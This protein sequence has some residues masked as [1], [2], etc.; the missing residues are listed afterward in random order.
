MACS[1]QT[2]AS[3]GV[4]NQS[5]GAYAAPER[6]FTAYVVDEAKD[7]VKAVWTRVG[8]AFE[9]RDGRGFSLLLNDLPKDRRIVVRLDLP[10]ERR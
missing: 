7:G 9:N 2:P 10:R 3:S 8:K 6:S 4:S 1:K 5:R